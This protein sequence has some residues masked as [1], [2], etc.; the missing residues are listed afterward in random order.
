MK[1]E[2]YDQKL[3]GEDRIETRKRGVWLLNNPSTNKGLAYTKG[4]RRRK[5]TDDSKGCAASAF[6]RV[7][8]TLKLPHP[9]RA[10]VAKRKSCAL[11]RGIP[12]RIPVPAWHACLT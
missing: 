10:S 7:F 4:E 6:F 12:M 5:H 1:G 11:E 8:K 2:T 3:G 9:I